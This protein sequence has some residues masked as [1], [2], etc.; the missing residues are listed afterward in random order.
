MQTGLDTSEVQKR[1]SLDLSG[2]VPDGGGEPILKGWI[3]EAGNSP[4]TFPEP[5]GK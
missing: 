4:D 1:N 3:M 2:K 5:R